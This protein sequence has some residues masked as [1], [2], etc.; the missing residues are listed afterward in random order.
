MLLNNNIYL[1]W[2]RL[3]NNIT[4]CRKALGKTKNILRKRPNN[5]EP[6]NCRND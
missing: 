5:L 3:E 1:E 2:D 6:R 4:S